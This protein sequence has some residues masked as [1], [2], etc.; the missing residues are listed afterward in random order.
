MVAF[1]A[2]YQINAQNFTVQGGVTFSN[3]TSTDDG[4]VEDNNMLTTFNIGVTTEFELSEAI[5]LQTGLIFTGKGAKAE[6]RFNDNN[7]IEAKFNPYYIEL[8][9][10][11]KVNLPIGVDNKFYIHAGPYVAMGVGGK[12]KIK[13]VILGLEENTSES[14]E[15]SNDDPL[16]SEEEDAGYGKLKRFDYGIQGGV[17]LDFTNFRVFLNGSF[18]L[19]K[20]NSGSEDNDNDRNK[21]R[22]IQLGIGIPLGR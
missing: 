22:V 19:A 10:S 4:N 20:V 2:C 7:Y 5:G 8:P 6:T 15:F 3:I 14:I 9:V 17:G 1:A 21:Y 18:G 16:T 13:T 12:T 11:L